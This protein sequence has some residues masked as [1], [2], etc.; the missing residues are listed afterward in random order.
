MEDSE[1]DRNYHLLLENHLNSQY[2]T[3]LYLGS[4]QKSLD[5]ILDTG[6]PFL[7]AA[8]D[9]CKSDCHTSVLFDTRK[10]TTFKMVNETLVTYNYSISF[11]QG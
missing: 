1:D 2:Y 8:T 3:T 4:K 11:V 9:K 10:S 5:F 6:S 7:W